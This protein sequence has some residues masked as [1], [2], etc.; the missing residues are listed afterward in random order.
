MPRNEY[1]MPGFQHPLARMLANQIEAAPRRSGVVS[2][3]PEQWSILRGIL[4]VPGAYERPLVTCSL[5][6]PLALGRPP[7]QFPRKNIATR[8]LLT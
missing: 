7:S 3:E 6:A 1:L 8:P 5:P 2:I 4:N